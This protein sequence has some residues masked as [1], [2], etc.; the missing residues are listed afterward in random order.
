[1]VS[2]FR[3]DPSAEAILPMHDA[4]PSYQFAARKVRLVGQGT[5]QAEGW[6]KERC[7]V[8]KAEEA[9]EVGFFVED[10]LP[11]L[12]AGHHIRVPLLFTLA[13]EGNAYFERPDEP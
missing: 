12:S 5:Y 6:D 3:P 7:V 8:C 1:M 9:T 13:R 11:P 2:L 10:A 4:T